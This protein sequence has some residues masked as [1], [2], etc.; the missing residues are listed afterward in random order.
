MTATAPGK[1]SAR[2]LTA[3]A[4]VAAGGLIVFALFAALLGGGRRSVPLDRKLLDLADDLRG[5]SAVDVIRVLTDL[6]SF[7]TVAALVF[8]VAILLLTRRRLAELIGLIAGSV[9][10]YGAVKLAKEG[11][12][13][14]RPAM[15][16]E[17]TQGSAF[18]S[19]HATYSTVWVAV[20][21]VLARVLPAVATRRVLIG[22]ALA[23]VVV[24]G[25]SRVYLRVHFF[26]DVAG[27]W[28]LG[29]A[30]LGGGAA[31]GLLVERIRNNARDPAPLP[32]RTI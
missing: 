8:G 17:P 4:A 30:V 28:A 6:G 14:P 7:T 22:A 32:D 2:D 23:V 18:P 15:A 12:D 16:L 21:L 24:V 26:S 25:L 10:L 31:A 11:I 3:A 1:D 19:G 20:A 9:V 27:G 29:A 13:R 5:E